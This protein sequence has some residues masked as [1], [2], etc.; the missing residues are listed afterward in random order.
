MRFLPFLA[1]RS[2]AFAKMG[3]CLSGGAEPMFELGH[4]LVAVSE[5]LVGA[6]SMSAFWIE[7]E[8]GAN[9]VVE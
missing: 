6:P 5:M 7:N 9:A 3:S 1:V 2:G 8:G 4:P